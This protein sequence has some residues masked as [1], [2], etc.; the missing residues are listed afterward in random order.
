MCIICTELLKHRLTYP[1]AKIAVK[2]LKINNDDQHI[3]LLDKALEED[4]FQLLGEVIKDL[5]KNSS[6]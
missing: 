6:K 1:E 3:F 5:D 2:E 4:D